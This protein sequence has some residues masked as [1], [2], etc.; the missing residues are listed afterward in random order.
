MSDSSVASFQFHRQQLAE[1]AEKLP[2][3][4]AEVVQEEQKNE[5][6]ANL[7]AACEALDQ[8]HANGWH[9]AQNWF[10]SFIGNHPQLTPIV[11]RDLLW[12]LGGDCLHF[13]SDEEIDQ[14]QKVEDK[15][16]DD[17]LSWSDAKRQIFNH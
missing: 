4:L 9:L 12:F 14:F 7:A 17:N 5:L 11:P 10:F 1:F 8:D 16:A 6:V 15:M 2:V 3:A 13:L